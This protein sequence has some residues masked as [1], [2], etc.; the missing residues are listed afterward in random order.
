MCSS[1]LAPYASLSVIANAR[2]GATRTLTASTLMKW[3]STWQRTKDLHA[4][5]P[6]DNDAKRV[7]K[8]LEIRE[9]LKEYKPGTRSTAVAPLPSQVPAWLPWFLDAYLTNYDFSGRPITIRAGEQGGAFPAGYPVQL[10]AVVDGVTVSLREMAVKLK[11]PRANWEQPV[12]TAT[13]AGTGGIE[14]DASLKGTAKPLVMG[15]ASPVPAVLIDKTLLVYQ[16]NSP[17]V[18]YESPHATTYGTDIMA[19]SVTEGA[20]TLDRHSTIYQTVTDMQAETSASVALWPTGID[21]KLCPTAGMFRLRNTAKGKISCT[22]TPGWSLWSCLVTLVTMQSGTITNNYASIGFGT[23]GLNSKILTLNMLAGAVIASGKTV[24]QLMDELTSSAACWWGFKADGS[25][26]AGA[27]PQ[28]LAGTPAASIGYS[29]IVSFTRE[30]GALYWRVIVRNNHNFDVHTA[31]DVLAVTPADS[32]IAQAYT[33]EWSDSIF[34]G[35]AFK[36]RHPSAA[37]MTVDSVLYRTATNDPGW[38]T[39]LQGPTGA[40]REILRI[41][42][43]LDSTEIANLDIGKVCTVTMPRLGLSAGRNYLVTGIQ[44]DAVRGT[45][46]LTLWG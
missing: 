5:A 44:T 23:P 19:V 6:Q 38:L 34:E 13:Y 28:D 43:R 10:V 17:D 46:D 37:E 24:S 8:E 21:Y 40:G 29:D 45:A 30:A 39:T 1:D 36:A 25:V 27:Y 32:A 12:A 35:A 41:T 31:A 33:R 9:W 15:Y 16:Y 18:L 2:H 11:S 20:N 22:V 4:L 7:D 14:G 42:A 26:L 3:W